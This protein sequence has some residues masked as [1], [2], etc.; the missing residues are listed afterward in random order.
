MARGENVPANF[1]RGVAAAAEADQLVIDIAHMDYQ[2]I[3]YKR[4]QALE[5]GLL[6]TDGSD[7]VPARISSDDESVRATLLQ[8]LKSLGHEAVA[9]DNGHAGLALFE[10]EQ[11][12]LVITD[13]VMPGMEGL[14]LI[15]T[16]QQTRSIN[17]ARAI[18][19]RLMGYI[20]PRFVSRRGRAIRGVGRLSGHGGLDPARADG[21]HRD[22]TVDEFRREGSG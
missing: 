2:R 6:I 4:E 12:D 19:F 15:I 5:L 1:A 20:I 18:P 16:T 22:A 3:A 9:A 10:A 17:V 21:V 11:F 14:E 7:Y 8:M 13:I